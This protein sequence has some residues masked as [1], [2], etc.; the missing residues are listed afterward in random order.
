MAQAALRGFVSCVQ[1]P[2]GECVGEGDPEPSSHNLSFKP[3]NSKKA[4]RAFLPGEGWKPVADKNT[5]LQDLGLK[6]GQRVALACEHVTTTQAPQMPVLELKSLQVCTG[7]GGTV[8]NHFQ[9]HMPDGFVP[10][11]TQLVKVRP[12]R[13]GPLQIKSVE[14]YETKNNKGRHTQHTPPLTAI[15]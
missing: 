8:D 7:L 10:E 1:L 6:G 2:C 11:H 9:L 12:S 4:R 5:T 13:T 15:R 3:Y 14:E